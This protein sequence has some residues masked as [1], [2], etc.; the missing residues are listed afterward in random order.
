MCVSLRSRRK[1]GTRRG[2]MEVHSSFGARR[3]NVSQLKTKCR[4]ARAIGRTSGCRT[5]V[6]TL[7]GCEVERKESRCR[8][9]RR[10]RTRRFTI[11][12]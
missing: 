12:R 1:G 2:R 9:A 3:L 6:R 7:C 8:P 11:G 4:V 10:A 5:S